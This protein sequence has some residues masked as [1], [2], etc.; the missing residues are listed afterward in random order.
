M[1]LIDCGQA[2]HVHNNEVLQGNKNAFT[3]LLDLKAAY[4]LVD[5]R[6][7]WRDLQNNFALPTGLIHQL[8][9]LFDKNQ[10]ELVIGGSR[11]NPINN[12]RG[13]LQGSSL[14]PILFNYFI[15]GLCRKLKVKGTPKIM[16]HGTNLNSLLFADDTALVAGNQQDMAKLLQICESWSLEV[17][18]V[19]APTKCIVLGPT[20]ASRTTPLRMYNTDLPSAEQAVYLGLPFT[21]R[22]ICW[23][24]LAKSRT[25]K[26]RGVIAM[27]APMG[28]NAKG[29]APAA[30][31]RIYK[32]FI[33]PVME[34]GLSLHRP[35]V[36]IIEMYE[37][38]QTL[39]L[40][41]LTSTPRNTSRAG[42]QRLL[43]IESM[44]QRAQEL[45][46]MW[47]GRLHN[48]TDASNLAVKVF[49]RALQGNRGRTGLSLPRHALDNILWSHPNISTNK[50]PI[51]RPVN[52]L[53]QVVPKILDLDTR[54]ELRRKSI[55]SL[56]ADQPNVAGAIQL[57]LD[58]AIPPFLRPK[59]GI[60]RADRWL[61]LQWRLGIVTRHEV[62]CNCGETLTR[63]HAAD[64]SGATALL[65]EL[66]PEVSPPAQP[67]HTLID[68]VLN[69][70]RQQPSQDGPAHAN[71]S[72]AIALIL[73]KCRGLQLSLEDGRWL[74]QGLDS[75]QHRVSERDLNA[76]PPPRSAGALRQSA[77]NA[78]VR[79]A[80]NRPLGRP[81]KR[82]LEDGEEEGSEVEI[83]RNSK[84]INK[85]GG[86]ER[87]LTEGVG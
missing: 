57:E 51:I 48:S 50:E 82:A 28:F 10:S 58:D 39:A 2:V 77:R 73:T 61:L 27:L 53:R 25:D 80:R 32:T 7:L 49:H 66:H 40:R 26:A 3:T 24:S 67:R 29:W 85:M 36:S 1:S 74:G 72:T 23:K 75:N 83:G 30:S 38:V 5:R 22:G 46:L 71:C 15:D 69:H 63:A 18:M 21:Q 84:R 62:C 13:L 14:S 20:A 70:Y 43:Q 9:D 42:L 86:S 17:G 65:R 4:D 55:I 54:L 8:Q 81:R 60:S 11:S 37:K 52:L 33:R 12:T 44:A 59:T 87:M 16:V 47:S 19:F 78:A 35:S 68:A 41:T 64:C 76:T 31:I 6:I 45:N 79:D 34:Y 56:E